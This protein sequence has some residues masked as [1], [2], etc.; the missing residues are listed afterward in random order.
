MG[1]LKKRGAPDREKKL[2]KDATEFVQ[3]LIQPGD[4]VTVN[5]IHLGKYAKRPSAIPL[6]RFIL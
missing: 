1:A 5:G 4:T 6:I 2:A 3:D